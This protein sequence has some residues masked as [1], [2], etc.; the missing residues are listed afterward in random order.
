VAWSGVAGHGASRRRFFFFDAVIGGFGCREHQCSNIAEQ[1]HAGSLAAARSHNPDAM[2]AHD[3]RTVV[4]RRKLVFELIV[5]DQR[6][7]DAVVGRRREHHPANLDGVSTNCSFALSHVGF[8]HFHLQASE[9]RS[10]TARLHG[11]D[12]HQNGDP[13]A[14]DQVAWLPRQ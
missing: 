2:G 13:Y 7:F 11:C 14:E 10:L 8:H 3:S 6:R 12:D 4:K 9:V 5:V 1:S